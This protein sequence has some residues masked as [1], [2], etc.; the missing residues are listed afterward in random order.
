MALN[1]TALQVLFD[2]IQTVAPQWREKFQEKFIEQKTHLVALASTQIQR[3]TELIP[4]NSFL[5]ALSEVIASGR[6]QIIELKSKDS[7][8]FAT[9][10]TIPVVAYTSPNHF[11]S[12]LVIPGTATALAREHLVKSNSNLDFSTKAISRS[13]FRGKHLVEYDQG[14]LQKKIRIPAVGT[15]DVWVIKKGSLFQETENEVAQPFKGSATQ[16]EQEGFSEIL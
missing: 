8:N 7:E 16:D 3:A 13:L 2:W 10:S 1:F 5:S 4:A 14:R 9:V 6:A 12:Y 15:V 11:G